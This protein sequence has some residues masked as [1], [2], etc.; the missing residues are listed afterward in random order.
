MSPVAGTAAVPSSLPAGE[1]RRTW[2]VVATGD[3]TFAVNVVPRH[4]LASLKAI[5]SPA[6]AEPTAVPDAFDSSTSLTA[7]AYASKFS[8]RVTFDRSRAGIV[9]PRT[10][11]VAD[12]RMSDDEEPI[13]MSYA[14]VSTTHRPRVTSQCFRSSAVSGRLTVLVR[15]AFRCTRSKARSCL[16]AVESREVRWWV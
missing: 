8:A 10:F 2:M 12:C 11:Q 5:Q 16:T 13:M 14:E 7:G 4:R 1:S 9:S 6:A 3:E 15:P